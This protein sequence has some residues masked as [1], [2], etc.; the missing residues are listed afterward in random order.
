MF[1]RTFLLF[2]LVAAFL[3]QTLVAQDDSPCPPPE[4]KKAQKLFSKA[5]DHFQHYEYGD[6]YSVL[7]QVVEEEPDYADAYYLMGMI[8]IKRSTPNIAAADRNFQKVIE[9]CPEYNPYVYYFLGDIAFGA[10]KFTEAKKYLDVFLKDVDKIKTDK[11]YDRAVELQKFA[12]FYANM[13]QKS[14]PF[15]PLPVPGLCTAQDEYLPIISP[16]NDL[17]LFTRVVKM[18]P[19]KND[20]IPKEKLN[21]VFMYSLRKDGFFNTGEEMPFPFNQFDNEGGAT[22]TIDNK[23]LFYTVCKY[24]K[25]SY[26]NCD[27]HT[28]TFNGDSWSEITPLGAAVNTPDAWESQPSISPDGKILYFVSDRK[29]GIGGYDIYQSTL[30]DQGEWTPAVNMGPLINSAGN[31]KSPFIHSDNITFY[32]SSDGH[33][34]MGKY[35]IFFSKRQESGQFSKPVN[36][37]YPINTPEDE[38]GFFASTD[39]HYGYFASNK[40]QGR[41]GWDI[42]Y[43]DLYPEARPE[44]VLFV[45]GELKNEETKEAVRGKI[46][47]KNVETKKVTEI[48]VDSITGEYAAVVLFRNDYML[49]VK[50]EGFGYES[51]YIAV[52]DTLFRM[53]AKVDLEIKPIEVGKAYKLNDIYFE[54]ASFE[55]TAGSKRVLDGFIQFLKDNPEIK[56]AIQG[57]TD[58]VGDDKSNQVLSENRAHSVYQYIVDNGILK[59]RLTYAGFGE[60]LPIASNQTAEGRAKNRRTVFVIT[61]K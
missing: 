48:P 13:L 20:L 10:Q 5:S 45:K 30:S 23:K 42:F 31:E 11:D 59:T 40:Y 38:V 37:G 49:T 22:L 8:N 39:G 14:I 60:N 16:D 46:E 12:T 35:D 26:F 3:T 7:K 43:F 61:G 27:I 56:I 18:P 15:N 51:K 57:Y 28:S 36:I 6:A 9:L 54:T 25:G 29:G 53:P 47:L 2:T 50:K 21:E 19:D 58:N 32:F 44:K 33:L 34:G 41:G 52:E 24:G 4:N 55:L 1:R 17:A